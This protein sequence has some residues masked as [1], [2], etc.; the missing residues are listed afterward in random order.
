MIGTDDD[1]DDEA[2]ITCYLSTFSI[3]INESLVYDVCL[4]TS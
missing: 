3:H 4:L 1:D 2:I